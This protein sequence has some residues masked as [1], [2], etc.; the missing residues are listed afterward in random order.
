MKHIVL[1][2]LSCIALNGYADPGDTLGVSLGST[3]SFSPANQVT[4]PPYQGG[5]AFGVNYDPN[6]NFIGIG[7]GY[8]NEEPANIVGVL[9]LIGAKSKGVNNVPNTKLT[10]GLHNMSNS[11]AFNIITTTNPPSLEATNGPS[12]TLLGSK[13]LFFEEID[14]TLG[15]Y[16][17][18]A[19]DDTIAVNGNLVVSVDLAE[20]KTAGDIVGFYSDVPG[21]AFGINFAFHKANVAGDIM[22]FT[23]NSVFQGAL[24]VSLAIFPVIAA[25]VPDAILETSKAFQ[26]VRALAMPNP[27][28]DV[29]NIQLEISETANYTVQ[30]VNVQ[31]QLVKELSL[32]VKTP[33]V[34]TVETTVAELES[35]TYF[36]SIISDTGIR[37]SKTIVLAH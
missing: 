33:G 25:D 28:N 21:N 12:V 16:N 14:T 17:Y 5:Y 23:S 30:L 34:H 10:F 22:W 3:P 35:G 4:L 11:G 1:F 2:A 24:D 20:L 18:V 8:I 29:L 32:G 15:A 36:Y 7:Q 37:F 9:S 19:F 6:N 13:S 31:G 27:A 26:G